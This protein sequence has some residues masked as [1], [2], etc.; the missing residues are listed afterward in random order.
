MTAQSAQI[1]YGFLWFGFG[2]V[3]SMFAGTTAKNRLKPILGPYYRLAYNLFAA[4]HIGA[5]MGFGAWAF[6]GGQAVAPFADWRPALTVLAI[7]GWA[8]MIL[9]LRTYDL[10]RLAGTAQIRAYKAG[11]ALDED[12]PMLVGRFHAY[13]R[14]PLYSAGMMI[15]WGAAWTD[16]GL[17]TACWGTLYL[18]I[19][20][21]FEERRLIRLYGD[22]YRTYRQRVPAF[23]PWRGRAI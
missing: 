10:G 19:G 3:H 12:E 6:A 1:L 2:V 9:A 15:L 16:L 5:I 7:A 22:A 20:A 23:V 11:Q 13:L 4:L 8:L 14:H 18:V 21:R 17:A